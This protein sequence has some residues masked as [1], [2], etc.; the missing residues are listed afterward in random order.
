MLLDGP[1]QSHR[2]RMSFI[3]GSYWLEPV[4]RFRVSGRVLSVKRYRHGELSD[5]SPLD[6]ALGWGDMADPFLLMREQIR[7]GQDYRLMY[8]ELP[9]YRHFS[10]DSLA[11]QTAN[12]HLI[13]ANDAVRGQLLRGLKLNDLVHLDGQLVHVTQL[14]TQ[15]P[16]YSSMV[17]DDVLHGAGEVLWVERVTAL[18]RAGN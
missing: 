5:I 6:L 14:R 18:T 7:I 16:W 10:A 1:K 2:S 8:W 4:E 12:L 17:R 13:P 3:H 11:R 15:L 9:E